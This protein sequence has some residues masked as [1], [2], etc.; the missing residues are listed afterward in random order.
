ML[1]TARRH[2]GQA[3]GSDEAR[4]FLESARRDNDSLYAA[5]LLILVLGFS[6]GRSARTDV[7]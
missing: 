1:P 6:E 3:L 7:G 2:K 5:Y 4:Q